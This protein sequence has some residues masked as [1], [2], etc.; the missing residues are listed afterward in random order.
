MSKDKKNK[1]D[2][3]MVPWQKKLVE[4]KSIVWERKTFKKADG[5][6]IEKTGKRMLGKISNITNV[7]ADAKIEKDAWGHE[8]C[9]LCWANISEELNDKHEGY[10]DGNDWLCTDCYN[11]YIVGAD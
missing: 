3:W 5:F 1:V 4:D 2:E 11:N 9:G 7:P 10:T 8:H 6:W